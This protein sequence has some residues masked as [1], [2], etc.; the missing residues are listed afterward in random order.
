MP[1]R[2]DEVVARE[3]L[4]LVAFRQLLGACRGKSRG[5]KMRADR[6]GPVGGLLSRAVFLLLRVEY[7]DLVQRHRDH[8]V[9]FS[10]GL[11]PQRQ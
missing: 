8:R 1:Y 11:R 3:R 9:V 4:R 2:L 5:E 7:R 10:H 6:R